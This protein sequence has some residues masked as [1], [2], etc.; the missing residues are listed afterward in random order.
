[1]FSYHTSIIGETKLY[2]V[3]MVERSLQQAFADKIATPRTALTHTIK[4]KYSKLLEDCQAEEI[5]FLVMPV[6]VLGGFHS[7]TVDIVPMLGRQLGK[8]DFQR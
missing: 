6:E 7:K 2:I 3:I 1:M 5:E 4:K 8:S